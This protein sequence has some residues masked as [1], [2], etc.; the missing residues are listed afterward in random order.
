MNNGGVGRGTRRRKKFEH[1][2][3]ARHLPRESR[4]ITRLALGVRDATGAPRLVQ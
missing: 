4:A 1:S 3:R 2:A